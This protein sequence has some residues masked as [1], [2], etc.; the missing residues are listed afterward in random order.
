M[1]GSAA[2][3]GP[4]AA[5]QR[6]GAGRHGGPGWVL[7][8]ARVCV[9]V[10]HAGRPLGLDRKLMAW[11]QAVAP[12]PPGSLAATHTPQQVHPRGCL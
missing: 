2:Q 8:E 6:L 3:L 1:V 7:W 10:C 5:G 4:D 11:A 12:A 9:C